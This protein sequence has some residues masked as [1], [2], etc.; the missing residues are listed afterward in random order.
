LPTHVKTFKNGKFLRIDSSLDRGRSRSRK[1]T[2]LLGKSAKSS[3]ANF[4]QFFL[5]VSR[6]N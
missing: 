3:V 5:S 2:M 1:E 6:P 4:I